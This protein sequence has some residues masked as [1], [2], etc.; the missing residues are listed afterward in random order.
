MLR[1]F[2]PDTATP[3]EGRPSAATK[4][5]RLVNGSANRAL[6]NIK[7]G[8]NG[9]MAGQQVTPGDKRNQAALMALTAKLKDANSQSLAGGGVQGRV[10]KMQAEADLQEEQERQA[11]AQASTDIK[12][13]AL[14]KVGTLEPH[15]PYGD[16][17]VTS[18]LDM[19]G[20]SAMANNTALGKAT[21]QTQIPYGARG[22]EMSGQGA[23][24]LQST[25]ASQQQQQARMVE[26]QMAA[27]NEEA[28]RVRE[29]SRIATEGDAWLASMQPQP[30]RAGA[31]TTLARR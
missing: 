24:Q 4:Q 2:F 10:G 7:R 27:A 11:L 18:A 3:F 19:H 23:R 25:I 21:P 14:R 9:P 30:A 5:K 15:N 20:A 17:D 31:V 8:T 12:S 6:T 1:D 26:Q 13:Q 16:L 22:T 28:R 29:R